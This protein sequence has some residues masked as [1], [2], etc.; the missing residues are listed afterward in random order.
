MSSTHVFAYSIYTFAYNTYIDQALILKCF[1]EIKLDTRQT[2][3]YEYK[4][5]Y[6][7]LNEIYEECLCKKKNRLLVTGGLVWRNVC[8]QFDLIVV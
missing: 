1:V 5:Q 3:I 7:V 8:F 4:R 2:W 6:V